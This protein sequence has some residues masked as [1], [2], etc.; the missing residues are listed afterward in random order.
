[1]GRLHICRVVWRVDPHKLDSISKQER[2]FTLDIVLKN[3]IG[4][5]VKRIANRIRQYNISISELYLVVSC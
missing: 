3:M 1:M 5:R 2:C 4:Y